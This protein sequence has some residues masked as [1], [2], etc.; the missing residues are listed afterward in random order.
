MLKKPINMSGIEA[1]L[2]KDL[3]T[4]YATEKSTRKDRFAIFECSKCKKHFEMQVKEAR[5]RKLVNALIA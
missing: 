5:S 3:G 1:K 2:I 4:K